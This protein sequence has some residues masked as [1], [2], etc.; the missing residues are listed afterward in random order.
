MKINY[1]IPFNKPYLSGN[2]IKY[3]RDAHRKRQL[4]GDGYYT[5][6][7]QAWLSKSFG[8]KFSLL[9]HS[10]TAALDM[11]AILSDIKPGDEAII[12]SYTFVSTANA[13]VLRMGVPVFIDIRPDNL[14]INEKLIEQAITENTKAIVVMHFA[15]V[16]CEMDFIQAI[17]KKHKLILLEDAA[18]AFMSKY[19]G[20]FLGSLG[21]MAALSFHETK[22]IISGEGGA[23]LLNKNSYIERAQIIRE[24]G[25]N[26]TKFFQG[27]IDKYTWI[28]IGS[29]YLPGEIIASFLM[30]QLEKATIITKR[31]LSLWNTYHHELADLEKREM[32]RRPVISSG[33][34]H[35][36]HMYYV[37]TR[38]V[39]ERDGLLTFLK[40]RGIMA[41]TH[42]VPLH[43]SPAGRKFGRYTGE[44][45][46]TDSASQTLIRLPLFYDLSRNEQAEILEAIYDYYK[47]L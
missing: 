37:L 42:Y 40:N 9:T 13:F 20:K 45:K 14:N 12:P 46:I 8:L 36:A 21:E 32:I 15:G 23:L 47:R 33:C 10:A 11:M 18:H 5:K 29:S 6:K 17:A 31:R 30:A 25:T 41:V 22:N 1:R 35:N 39:S 34:D 27:K 24:K 3:I 28:D 16:G 2:E 43:S 38:K 4:A 44:M 19:K 7:C 26:R